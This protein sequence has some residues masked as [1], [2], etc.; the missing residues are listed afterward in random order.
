MALFSQS[1]WRDWQS[2]LMGQALSE[3][4]PAA[5][6][7]A[8]FPYLALQAREKRVQ[9]IESDSVSVALIQNDQDAREA[10]TRLINA[11]QGSPWGEGYLESSVSRRLARKILLRLTAAAPKINPNFIT[12]SDLLLGLVAVAG[13][14]TGNYWAGLG[15]A[16]LLPLV[17]VLDM[18][19]GLLARLT[20]QESREGRVLD[21]Y[22][23]TIL[24]LLIFCGIAV[25]QY[26]ATGRVLF[27]FLLIPRTIGYIWCWRL[28]NP[29]KDET[30]KTMDG[31]SP[32]EPQEFRTRPE[33]ALNETIS[34][35]FFYLIVLA[36]LFNILD[37]LIIAVAIGANLFGLFLFWRQRQERR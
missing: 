18:L 4:A 33:K 21:L 29:L 31:L 2:W 17:I 13:F 25:G 35:D 3:G 16:L 27:L 5:P 37:W 9:G 32:L 8:L 36:A 28:T 20:F 22:G 24:N 10:T 7:T 23:D 6:D 15:A 11:A 34:R 19:D 1:A 30:R 26:R 14:L 12:V